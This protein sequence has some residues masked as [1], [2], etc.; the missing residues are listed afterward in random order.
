MAAMRHLMS[1]F[2]KN[3]DNALK[4]TSVTLGVILELDLMILMGVFHS[5]Q[6]MTL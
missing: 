6:P 3:L 5:E 1:E 4:R 2:K